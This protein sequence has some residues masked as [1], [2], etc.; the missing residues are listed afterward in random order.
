MFTSNN[1]KQVVSFPNGY[2]ASIISH[3]DS[4]GG[5]EGLFEIAIVYDGQ[6]CYDTP[7]TDD[8]LGWLSFKEVA[9][10]LK[11]IELLPFR[12]SQAVEA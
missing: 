8:V 6:F 5:N 4:Y 3:N 12:N 10:T 1:Y 2:S 9:D 7:I 11:A